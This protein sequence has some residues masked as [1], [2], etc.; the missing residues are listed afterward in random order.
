MKVLFDH[1]IFH[2]QY[3]GAS[4]YFAMLLKHLPREA[5]STTARFSSNEYVR[6]A[7]LFPT[8]RRAFRGQTVIAE[9]VNRPLTQ[10]A[11]RRGRYDV[12]HQ[13]N[14]SVSDL[15]ANG[16]KPMVT[17]FH[18]TNLSTFDPHPHIVERQRI[19]LERADAIICVSQHTAQDM[20]SLF[21]VEE[22]K[23]HVIYHGIERPDL[24]SL[25]PERLCAH[26]YIL[27]VGRRSEYK[28]F[29]RFIDA[30]SEVRAHHPSLHVVC[31]GAPFSKTELAS[32]EEC[33][34]SQVMH[35]IYASEEE[36]LRLYRDAELFVFPSLYE[37]F[38]MPILEAWTCHC[39]VVLSRASCFPEI[40][41]DAAEY[42]EAR[43]TEAMAHAICS[44]LESSSLRQELIA[45]GEQRVSLF[46]WQRC[47]D[48][49]MKIYESLI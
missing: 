36:M 22:K 11:L 31:T 2:Y 30:F 41:A 26:P 7:G 27:Y 40:A 4:K 39:P 42:F 8:C 18:D 47:A 37:G 45:R 29:T 38:G 24:S 28:N 6:A 14:F 13:T 16:E 46:S 35:S 48:E 33:G 21:H 25:P 43:D 32:F 1:Q 44:V 19:S 23:V 34:I 5:W 49:H 10:C 15:K 9:L 20:L 12:F 3:G 17:T